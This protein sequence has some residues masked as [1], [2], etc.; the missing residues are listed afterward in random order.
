M[1]EREE[2]DACDVN[3]QEREEEDA[4]DVNMQERKEDPPKTV[5]SSILF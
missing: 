1:Q 4:C 3:M 5:Q 2:E